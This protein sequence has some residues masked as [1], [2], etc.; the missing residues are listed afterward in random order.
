MNDVIREVGG[1]E[2]RHLVAQFLGQNIGE[3]KKLDSDIIV[4]S[5]TLT[6]NTINLHQIGSDIP[7]VVPP[8]PQEF[9]Q[10]QAPPSIVNTA[11]IQSVV[12]DTRAVS[13]PTSVTP[14]NQFEFNFSL[15]E[16]DI[17]NKLDNIEKQ[18][19]KILSLLEAL[20]YKLSN[21][22]ELSLDIKK[23]NLDF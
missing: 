4:K 17:Y 10:P 11:P 12:V 1:Q 21:S 18:N 23:K 7:V 20:D 5:S 3:L 6:G 13:T 19:R 15:S 8:R 14:T 22:K 16:K 2:A 9:I